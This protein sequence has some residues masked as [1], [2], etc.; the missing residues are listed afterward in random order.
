MGL[1]QWR[2]FFNSLKFGLY[3]CEETIAAS[4]IGLLLAGSARSQTVGSPVTP[5]AETDELHILTPAALTARVNYYYAIFKAKHTALKEKENALFPEE[6]IDPYSMPY[7]E[8]EQLFLDRRSF[9]E[10]DLD[11][12]IVYCGDM[13]QK[14]HEEQLK[15]FRKYSNEPALKNDAQFREDWLDVIGQKNAWIK[16]GQE[17]KND[18]QRYH[19]KTVQDGE[20]F[21]Q[22]ARRQPWVNAFNIV[23]PVAPVAG[24]AVA[25]LL[26]IMLYRRSVIRAEEYAD[27]KD[28]V[29]S[30]IR[31]LQSSK[32]SLVSVKQIIRSEFSVKFKSRKQ[33][34]ELEAILLEE[35]AARIYSP[36]KQAPG[37][38]SAKQS[39]GR[40]RKA[41]AQKDQATARAAKRAAKIASSEK[42]TPSMAT[43]TTPTTPPSSV[44]EITPV[45]VEDPVIHVPASVIEPLAPTHPERSIISDETVTHDTAHEILEVLAAGENAIA[46]TISPTEMFSFA[47]ISEMTTYVVEEGPIDRVELPFG[48]EDTGFLPLLE[49]IEDVTREPILSATPW[50]E[51]LDPIIRGILDLADNDAFGDIV[52]SAPQ[53]RRFSRFLQFIARGYFDEN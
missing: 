28:R 6:E 46:S 4:A 26:G 24:L 7:P 48:L 35:T 13:S 43:N 34:D 32:H 15:L 11:K 22:R 42:A 51:I 3:L 37:A 53:E 45:P 49:R 2:D 29:R 17:T 20:I 30:R 21:N 27:L 9:V 14:V 19:D 41:K 16:L 23:R 47:V 1:T 12:L 25:S 50:V 8:L 39:S 44:D 31:E 52:E 33:Q 10:Q 38:Q 40:A 18:W 36:Q 5:A